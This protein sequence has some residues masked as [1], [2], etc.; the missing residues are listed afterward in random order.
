MPRRAFV[1][2]PLA[3]TEAAEQLARRAARQWGLVDPVMIRV[4]MN[5]IYATGSSVLRVSS[6][7]APAVASIHLAE[8]LLEHGLRVTRPLQSDAIQ[9]GDLSVT[10]WERIEPTGDPIDWVEVGRMIRHVHELDRSIIPADYPLPQ[11][12]DLPWWDFDALLDEVGEA[13]DEPALAG[14]IAAVQRWPQWRHFE[15]S[16][17]CHG[18][19]H[20][21]NVMMSAEGPVLIDWDL[22]CLAPPGWDHA[23]MMTWASRWGGESGLYERMADGYGKSMYGDDDADAFAELRLVAATLMR[24][25]AGLRNTAAMPEAQRRLAHWRGDPDA[26]TWRAQ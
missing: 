7:S 8:R 21:G 25:K 5:A 15:N 9:S 13:I 22:L 4:G 12:T 2:R 24:V 3:D 10:I 23:P 20:P 16:V 19:V 6:P 11:P 18:D 1:D 14:I 26:P 17:V